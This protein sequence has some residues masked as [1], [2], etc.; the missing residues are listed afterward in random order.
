MRRLKASKKLLL[1]LLQCCSLLMFTLKALKVVKGIPEHYLL[2]TLRIKGFHWFF[3]VLGRPLSR[4]WSYGSL[5][6][7]LVF[8]QIFKDVEKQILS[9]ELLKNLNFRPL[10]YSKSFNFKYILLEIF[11][12]F[13]KFN[14]SSR[15]WSTMNLIWSSRV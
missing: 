9:I 12:I 2:E 4:F 11:R 7:A 15:I 10:T 1:G 8:K 13:R 3:R 5:F 6:W 14:D